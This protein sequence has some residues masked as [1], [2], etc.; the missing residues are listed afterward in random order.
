MKAG[1]GFT[2]IEVLVALLVFSLIAS[3]AAHV[4]SQYIS[5]YERIRNKTLASWIA[6]N[7][8]NEIRL[9]EKLP[10][11]TENS[12]DIDYG[13]FR[14]RVT[15]KVQGTSEPS[16]RRIEVT[17]ARYRNGQ[18]DPVPVHTLSAFVGEKQ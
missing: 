2:L 4:G 10:Q 12:R 3:T 15:T 18:S 9:E 11:I 8:I 14:W 13:P 17:A 1:Q 16:M 5:S 7:R 6:D